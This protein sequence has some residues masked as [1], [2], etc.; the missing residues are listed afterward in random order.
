[1]SQR[2]SHFLY[3]IT[4]AVSKALLPENNHGRVTDYMLIFMQN[5]EGKHIFTLNLC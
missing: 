1:M 4:P 3:Y 2:G 5:P